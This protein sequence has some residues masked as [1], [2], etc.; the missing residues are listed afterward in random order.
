MKTVID[1]ESRSTLD[2]KRVGGYRYAAHP[3]TEIIALS[4]AIGDGPVKVIRKDDVPPFAR[5]LKLRENLLL[6]AHG[7]QFEYAM[8]HFIMHRRLGAPS[9]IDP[10][11]WTC[12]LARAA[13]C[14]FPQSLDALGQVLG[15][16]IKKD[17]DGRAAMLKLCKPT[18]RDWLGEPVYNE[19]PS[20]YERM[21]AYNGLDVEATRLADK[22]LP[23]I[24]PV[25]RAIFDLD[26]VINMRGMRADTAMAR[27]ASR[28][29][30]QLETKLNAELTKLT[31]GAVSAVSRLGEMKRYVASLGVTLPTKLSKDTGEEG[32]TLNVQAV[33]DLLAA[34][35]TPPLAKQVLEIRAQAGKTSSAK[36]AAMLEMADPAHGDRLRGQY[37]YWGAGP[38][39]W[40]GRGVQPQ[41]L[42]KS[43]SSAFPDGIKAP[44]QAAI[45]EDILAGDVDAFYAKYGSR[46]LSALSGVVRGAIVPAPGKVFVQADL[47]AIEVRCLFWEAG[48]ASALALYSQGKSPYIDMANYIYRRQDIAKGSTEYDLGKRT[49]LGA[50]F[51]CGV[52]RYIE[53]VYEDTAKVGRPIILPREIGER[54]IKSYREKYRTVVNLWYS[55][56][57]AAIAAVR[58]PGTIHSTAGGKV[59]YAMSQDR[60]FLLCRLPSGR[61]I[62]YYKPALV[63]GF[64]IFCKDPECVHWKAMDDSK[65]PPCSRRGS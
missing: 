62:F 29:A 26:L 5:N 41:N 34:P 36:Y 6:V 47:N 61:F 2:I 53:S 60:R 18:G 40:A 21:Y 52:D 51:G 13:M 9:L 46:A 7:V 48:D 8:W 44:Q 59:Q 38:G 19:D 31:G 3:S 1:L 14:G 58:Q 4:V 63:D 27:S 54:A 25:D 11:F 33:T 15:L 35:S 65:C 32:E 12:T 39:R 23:D 43:A 50:G 55:A 10:K 37:Q 57:A 24:L 17:L 56:E 49:I 28:M 45:I 64:R 16:P 42:P 30:E 22:V 20:L